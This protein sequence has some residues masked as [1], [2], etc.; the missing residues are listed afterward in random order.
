MI[1][2]INVDRIRRIEAGN[3]TA[4]IKLITR[5][6][7]CVL[8]PQFPLIGTGKMMM[9]FGKK[10][11]VFRLWKCSKP[12]KERSKGKKKRKKDLKNREGLVLML[13]IFIRGHIEPSL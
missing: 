7:P 11:D 6:L 8:N 9:K 2:L 1:V 13:K 4:I 3:R 10:K 5:P 12:L